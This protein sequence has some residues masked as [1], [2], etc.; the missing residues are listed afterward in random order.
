MRRKPDFYLLAVDADPEKRYKR[1][2]KRASETDQVSFKEFIDNESRE[3]QSDDPAK[4]NLVRCISMADY[5]FNND[6]TVNQLISE[7]K[8]VM[9]E[10]KTSIANGKR[11]E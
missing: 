10:I 5:N 4:Q 9:E 6:G 3:L 2:K 7:V 8:R 1:I 11:K